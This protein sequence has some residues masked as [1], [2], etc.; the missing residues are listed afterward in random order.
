MSFFNRE[1]LFQLRPRYNNVIGPEGQIGITGLKGDQ[2]EMFDAKNY[3]PADTGYTLIP[4]LTTE[5]GLILRFG[6]GVYAPNG[7]IYAIPFNNNINYVY[8]IDTKTDT[9]RTDVEGLKNVNFGPLSANVLA[10]NNKIYCI[11]DGGT[12]SFVIIDTIGHTH[13]RSE[14]ILPFTDFAW[15]GAVL[16]PNGKIYCVPANYSSVLVI[17]PETNTG[18]TDYPGLTGFDGI[19][20]WRGGVLATNGKIYCVPNNYSSVLV[21][22]PET[23]TG[24][25]DYPGLTGF[26][27]IIKWSGGVLAPNGKIY[28]CP[29]NNKSVLVIDPDTNIGR[30]N[31]PGLTNIGSNSYKNPILA[32]NGKIYCLPN[33]QSGGTF[34]V[35]DTIT[36]TFETNIPTMNLNK[37]LPVSPV[38]PAFGNR[39][40]VLAPN[41]CIYCLPLSNPNVF[42]LK[43]GLPK[44]PN[45]MMDPF[46]NKY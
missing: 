37:T 31:I 22:D 38:A 36:N 4:G 7:N 28:C 26:D 27:G 45:W 5:T 24:I 43:T 10:L 6:G 3:L 18:I 11:P 46:F 19:G 42:K 9:G 1:N 32:P 29:A 8:V 41:G 30:T 23:N 2:W 20:K 21:I 17:D 33:T 15:D 16:A 39:S 13:T 35:I 14:T 40:S 12:T 34:L 25:T 44:H